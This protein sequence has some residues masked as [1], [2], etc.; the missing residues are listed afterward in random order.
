MANLTLSI[1]DDLL[2]RARI[3]ALEG[4]TS[5]NALVRNYLEELVDRRDRERQAM[6]SFL[7]AAR[8]SKSSSGQDGRTWTREALYDRG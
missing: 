3:R 4:N 2:R 6:D 7:R 1:D 8:R 5:V